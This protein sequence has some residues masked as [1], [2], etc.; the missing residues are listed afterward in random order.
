MQHQ[1]FLFDS[2]YAGAIDGSW[3]AA[4]PTPFHLRLAVVSAIT[5]QIAVAAPD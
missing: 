1:T 5:S 2:T 3:P 4:A